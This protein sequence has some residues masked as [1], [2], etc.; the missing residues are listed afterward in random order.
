[1]SRVSRRGPEAGLAHHGRITEGDSEIVGHDRAG[2]RKSLG[3]RIRTRFA[4]IGLD[5]ELP[6]LR[7]EVARPATFER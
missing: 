7:G 2:A 1:M 6:E 3:S 4:K 5:D